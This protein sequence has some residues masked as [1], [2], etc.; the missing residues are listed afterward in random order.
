MWGSTASHREAGMTLQQRAHI[1]STS[2]RHR[3][4]WSWSGLRELEWQIFSNKATPHNLSQTV[5]PS[6]DWVFTHR[7]LWGPLLFKPPH[8]L[9][10]GI[11]CEFGVCSQTLDIWIVVFYL[12]SILL[13]RK[14]NSNIIP[15]PGIEANTFQHSSSGNYRMRVNRRVRAVLLFQM[16]RF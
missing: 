15:R 3:V 11:W 12:V 10:V 2:M 1:S 8:N 6:E 5:P 7:S 16:E 13:R 4:N 14:A 9:L